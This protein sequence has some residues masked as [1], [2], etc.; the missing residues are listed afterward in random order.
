MRL[1]LRTLMDTASGGSNTCNTGQLS[2][3]FGSGRFLVGGG[4]AERVVVVVVLVRI[5]LL[6]R[7]DVVLDQNNCGGTADTI[8]TFVLLFFFFLF[9]F[10]LNITFQH[11][12]FTPTD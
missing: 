2:P 10:L 5:T 6:C 7:V 11:D 9:G 12:L 4:G 8:N 3:Q 1:D